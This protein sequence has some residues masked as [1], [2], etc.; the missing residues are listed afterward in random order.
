MKTAVK[1]LLGPSASQFFFRHL[2]GK[3]GNFGSVEWLG[4]PVWY[5]TRA[6]WIDPTAPRW[7]KGLQ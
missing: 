6:A 5:W 2:I 1:K 3:T 4:Y 7:R